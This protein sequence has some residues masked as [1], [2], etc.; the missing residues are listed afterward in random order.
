MHAKWG[1]LL[2]PDLEI[3]DSYVPDVGLHQPLSTD[4]KIFVGS[5]RAVFALHENVSPQ[6]PFTAAKSIVWTLYSGL[7]VSGMSFWGNEIEKIARQRETLKPGTRPPI[8]LNDDKGKPIRLMGNDIRNWILGVLRAVSV[9]AW[10]AKNL[11][12]NLNPPR[13]LETIEEIE[14]QK[15]GLHEVTNE[16]LGE[17][18]EDY[19]NLENWE[20][21]LGVLECSRTLYKVWMM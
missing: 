7:N 4:R 6:I 8:K 10:R 5:I 15:Q 13:R 18:T 1:P 21:M 17:L 9:A 2:G 12:T 20:A 11:N 16:D 14:L 3:Q 19:T